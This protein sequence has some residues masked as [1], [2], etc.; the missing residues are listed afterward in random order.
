M[1]GDLVAILLTIRTVESG[2]RYDLP[3]N[4]GGASGAYQYIDSTWN[5]FKGYPQ[6]YL[7]PTWIQDERALADVQAILAQWAGDVSMIPVIWYYPKAARDP[8]LM[9]QVPL[10][11]SGNRLTVREY[12]RRWLDVLSFI[13]GNPSLYRPAALPPELRFLAGQPPELAPD[14]DPSLPGEIAFPVLGRA[15]MA[16]P[17]PCRAEICD[18][19]TDAVIYGQQL[20]PI[21]AAHEG[22]VT[23]VTPVDPLTGGTAV[24]ITDTFGRTYRYT[25]FNDDSF[26]THDGAAHPSLRLTSLVRIGGTVRAGQIIGFMGDSDPMPSGGETIVD[27][28]A[29]VWPHL[30]LVIRD[31][32]GSRLDADALVAQAQFRQACHVG[33]GPWSLGPNPD[34]VEGRD[35]AAIEV[36]AYDNGGWTFHADGSVTAYGRSALIL[37]PQD[38]SW[39]PVVP[40]GFGARGA[41]APLDWFFPIEL[42]AALWVNSAMAEASLS[43]T[44]LLR[45]G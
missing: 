4:R 27:P 18:V 3:P 11:S 12:Q 37:A 39:A 15:V 45:R 30:R 5:S 24:T 33:I 19:G 42:D 38:C 8:A 9:D 16:L 40:H 14:L 32:D 44:L 20:Q 17:N 41:D 1:S 26:G 28:D 13:T 29:Q 2:E 23:S 6:A 31:V 36:T 21:L 43:P 25:G 34:W 22:V 10:P 35:P 7:A